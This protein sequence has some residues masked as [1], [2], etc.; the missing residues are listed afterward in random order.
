MTEPLLMLFNY[1]RTSLNLFKLDGAW[2][3]KITLD[4]EIRQQYYAFNPP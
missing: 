4:K 2:I 1:L 3:F